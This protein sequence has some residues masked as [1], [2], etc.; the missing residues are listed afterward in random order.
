MLIRLS[1]FFHL[2]SKPDER[3]VQT[4]IA[5]V[6]VLAFCIIVLLLLETAEQSVSLGHHT[7]ELLD[8]IRSGDY[9]PPGLSGLLCAV[10]NFLLIFLCDEYQTLTSEWLVNIFYYTSEFS[11]ENTHITGEVCF[12]QSMKILAMALGARLSLWSSKRQEIPNIDWLFYSLVGCGSFLSAFAICLTSASF[13][14]HVYLITSFLGALPGEILSM[15]ISASWLLL[16]IA[17]LLG[18][19]NLK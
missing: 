14:D 8:L 13:N 19:S 18:I 15:T 9:L 2:A 10:V 11:L 4:N 7:D 5:R 3:I 17:K 12:Q 1:F 16:Y 6:L